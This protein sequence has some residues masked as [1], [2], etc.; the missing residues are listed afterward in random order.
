VSDYQTVLNDVANL[1]QILALILAIWLISK[2]NGKY[3]LDGIA[4]AHL[5]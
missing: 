5:S 2:K 1:S 4:D 3:L